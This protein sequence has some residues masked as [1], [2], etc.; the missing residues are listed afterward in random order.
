VNYTILICASWE[1]EEGLQDCQWAVATFW[2][3]VVEDESD[4]YD[5]EGRLI[6]Q[7]SRRWIDEQSKVHC[8]PVD[9]MWSNQQFRA[10]RE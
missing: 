4:V 5:R 8:S 2:E 10:G 1:P 7:A 3:N 9:C 6:R